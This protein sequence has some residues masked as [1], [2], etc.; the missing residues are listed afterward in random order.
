[1]AWRTSWGRASRSE[2][3]TWSPSMAPSRQSARHEAKRS[4]ILWGTWMVVV[5]LRF[6]RL[7]RK[8]VG[9]VGVGG[10]CCRAG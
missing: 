7:W 10:R 1:M 3:Q 4:R 2:L 9:R 8:L 6:L 5:P